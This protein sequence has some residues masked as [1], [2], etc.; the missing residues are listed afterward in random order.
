MNNGEDLIGVNIYIP[1]IKSGATTNTYG[2]YSLSLPRGDYELV[3]SYLG[4]ETKNIPV[5][6][7][8]DLRLDI[9]LEQAVNLLQEVVVTSEQKNVNVISSEMSVQKLSSKIIKAIPAMM[10]EVDIIKAIQLLPGVQ[11]V[12]EG[13]SSFSVRGGGHDQ[14]LILFDEATIY[15]AS[16]LMG[17]FSVFN[18]DII[19]DVI[20][21]KG[22]IPAVYGG[23][24]SSLMDVRTKDGNNQHFAGSG[25]IGLISSR[26][27]LEGP[28]VSDKASFIV[29]GRRTYA[30]IFLPLAANESLH[31]N[32]LYF[33]DLNAKLNYR[34]NDK[35][36]VFVSGYMG[37]DLFAN[38]IAEM[39]FGNK[40]LTARWNSI[41]TPRLFSNFSF[42]ASQ[43]DYFIGLNFNENIAQDWKS[44]LRDF[45]FK[46]DFSYHLNPQNNIK[47][48]YNFSYHTFYP[49][50]G[51]GV[52]E[53]TII[54]KFK[55]PQKYS[56][57]QAIYI[58]NETTLFEK[59]VLR[60][61]LRYSIFHNIGNGKEELLLNNY[62]VTDT[63]IYKKGSVYH[64]QS[65]FEPRAGINYIFDGK[66]SV[67]ASYSRT[68]QYIQL[69]SNSAAGSPLDV[70]F[71]VSKNIKPQINDQLAV[72]YFR[73]FKNNMFETSIEL[74]YK[75]MKHVVDF[76]D[77]ASLLGNEYLD[78]ELRFGTGYAY[79]VELMLRKNTGDLTGWVSY[80]Y[81]RSYRKIDEVNNEEWYR[82]PFDRPNN[83]SV[84][85]NYELSPR[86]TV[87]TNWVYATGV[88][89]T[90]PEGRFEVEGTYVPI[91]SKR[92]EYRYPDYHRMDLSATWKLKPI[93]KKFNHELN[94]SVYNLY[95]KKNP[96]TIFFQQ[97]EDRPDVTYAEM[98]YLFSVVPSITWNFS[99]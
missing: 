30:D 4:Y 48:G 90:Y 65:R 78:K 39:S 82:S 72:G 31:D 24:L 56:A 22:D 9:K 29:A 60:Y 68:A 71:Q 89:V 91:Y 57:D 70:W 51:G 2:F 54:S 10:G 92:N 69:A 13:S 98:L 42:V 37:N 80:T 5:K 64:T 47:F 74:Y 94:L 62:A 73:N 97:E 81:S 41:L 67:K 83:V 50:E 79:G 26:L 38:N 63:A 84:V 27:M 11:S 86:L 58:S 95:G 36:R 52:G 17:F 34:I 44:R 15:S 18:N 55:L 45:G 25:G 59:L 99:F 3:V 32:R 12:S 85:L 33:Y 8:G 14:N 23:R 77:R 20:L 1:S 96:W 93:K 7:S 61:G 46:A 35:N 28:I 66:H 75:D 6:L 88:P 76:K 43:Y 53:N 87:S 40:T 19:K 21:Y 16:H 49:G